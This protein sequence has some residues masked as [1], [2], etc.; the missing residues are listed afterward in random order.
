[1]EY[2]ELRQDLV[3][4]EWVII[5]PKRFGRPHEILKNLVKR[6]KSPKANCFFENPQKSGQEEAVYIYP[7][8]PR[9]QS[10]GVNWELQI[11]PNKYPALVPSNRKVNSIKHGAYNVIPGVGH[12]E[13]LI[14]RVHDKN[15][16]GLLPTQAL[17]VFRAFRRRYFDFTKD[18]NVSYV[19]IFH[20]WGAQA[21]ASVYHPHYQIIAMPVVPPDVTRSLVGSENYFKK[22]GVCAHCAI[23]RQE[24]KDRKRIIFENSGAMA[25]VP[26]ASLNPYGVSVFPKKHSAFFEESP[27]TVL[28][29]VAE[30]LQKSLSAIR[31]NLNDPDY[32]FFIH[33]S[34]IKNKKQYKHYH[35]HIEILPKF[36][37]MG[38]FEF[39]TGA[40]INVVDPDEAAGILRK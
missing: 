36:S 29:S 40:M 4:G 14:T 37:T 16:E 30:I 28:K 33:T 20:N 34:P 9:R 21:G 2:S 10:V 1:M 35:W 7:E 12:H 25:F 8:E 38:G 6:E 39:G 15:F 22:N 23:L 13:L 17:N 19:S 3:S 5:A 18:K 31:K 26:F 32:N 11:V 27:D 24:K